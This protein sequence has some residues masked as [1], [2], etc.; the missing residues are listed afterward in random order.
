[1]MLTDGVT[2]HRGTF[3]DASP[4]HPP[5]PGVEERKRVEIRSILC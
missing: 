2:Q 3:I 4:F 1:M 5:V